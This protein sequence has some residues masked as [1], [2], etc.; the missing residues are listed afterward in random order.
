MILRLLGDERS[1]NEDS[2]SG[3]ERLLEFAQYTRPR[4][5]RGHEVPE[6]LLSGNHGAIARWRKE[7]SL[8]RT[9]RR[10]AAAEPLER[11]TE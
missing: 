7:Q 8:E 1:S 2:F 5:Y 4:E 3:H 6:I 9:R 10:Q 11:R